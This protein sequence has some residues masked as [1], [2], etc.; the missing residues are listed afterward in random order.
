MG[1]VLAS[2]QETFV[3]PNKPT[4]HPPLAVFDLGK[5][6][7]GDASYL[8]FEPA[9]I[10]ERFPYLRSGIEELFKLLPRRTFATV[11]YQYRSFRAGEKTAPN[12]RWH[13]DGEESNNL[14][15]C[16]GTCGTLFMSQPLTVLA[17]TDLHTRIR[18]IV[19][20]TKGRSFQKFE[21]P[22][23]CPVTYSSLDVHAAREFTEDGERFFI[24]LATSDKLAPRN[25]L[26]PFDGSL[27]STVE[28]A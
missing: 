7:F 25:Y 12:T 28:H 11:D 15:Y 2:T 8:L 27:K 13:C 24:R 6:P 1:N 3:F 20:A 22:M 23:G 26:F 9:I 17:H 10:Y 5:I 21:V 18:L 19:D 4:V 16:L 14:I